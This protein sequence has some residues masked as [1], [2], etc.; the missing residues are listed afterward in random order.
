[1]PTV[2]SDYPRLRHCTL[3]G[4]RENDELVIVIGSD[5]FELTNVVGSREEFL[6]LKRYFDGRHSV[7]EISKITS[8]P[9]NDVCDVIEAF[10][11]LGMLRRENSN[12]CVSTDEFISQIQE[13]VL[14]WSRQLGYHRLFAGLERGELRREVFLGLLIETFHYVR[15]APKHAA[16]AISNSTNDAWTFL[17]SEY[18]SE[19]YDH[20]KLVSETLENLGMKREDVLSAHPLIGTMSLINMLCEIGRNNTLSY[21]A[22]TAL[23]EAKKENFV[24]AKESF[25][26]LAVGFG[27]TTNDVSPILSHMAEDVEAD[28][29]SL[30][31][32]ALEGIDSIAADEAHRIVNDLHDL[33]H[34]FDQFHDQIVQYYSDISNY[35]PRLKVDYFCL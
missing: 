2:A 31:S 13:S 20:A 8:L 15:N 25:E 1:M 34:S 6:N 17:L 30:L 11:D 3:V 22:C 18:L 5:Y 28:H 21:L 9:E 4:T 12:E 26:Q 14:M 24:E 7:S 33:K 16:N 23:F 19:E 32:E 10:E 35:I 27:F 29:N